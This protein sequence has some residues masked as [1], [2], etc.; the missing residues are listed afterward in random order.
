[1]ADVPELHRLLRL[2]PVVG[3]QLEQQLQLIGRRIGDNLTAELIKPFTAPPAHG[4]RVN[5]VL[6]QIADHVSDVELDLPALEALIESLVF[7]GLEVLRQQVSVQQW[8]QQL[9]AYDAKQQQD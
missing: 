6:G 3:A 9:E 7:E 4:E 8:K 1:L 5:P 2:M